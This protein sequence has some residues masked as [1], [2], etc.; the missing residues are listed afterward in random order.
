MGILDAFA[1]KQEVKEVRTSPVEPLVIQP[2]V[3]SLESSEGQAEQSLPNPTGLVSIVEETT[4]EVEI[5][6]VSIERPIVD[7]VTKETIKEVITEQHAK[8]QLK[9]VDAKKAEL[10]FYKFYA[11]GTDTFV[12]EVIL[13]H[14]ADTSAIL[15]E[16]EVYILNLQKQQ[17]IARIQEQHTRLRRS[18][19]IQGRR[20]QNLEKKRKSDLN[21]V[22][23]VDGD[24]A[25]A[26]AKKAV[27]KT[28]S[29]GLSGKAKLV[30]DLMAKG[31]SEAQAKALVG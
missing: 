19:V 11:K 31:L 20:S 16:L 10:E 2:T 23:L 15:D 22:P 3:N 29:S 28:V 13:K 30:A 7:N 18:L 14:G 8:L 6:E 12:N 26:K 24:E 27:K 4:E 5:D 1:K 25:K 21:Y 9:P 17:A